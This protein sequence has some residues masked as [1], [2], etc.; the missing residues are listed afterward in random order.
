MIHKWLQV[1]VFISLIAGCASQPSSY[2][3]FTKMLLM[4]YLAGQ[5]KIYVDGK[6][7]FQLVF[8]V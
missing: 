1:L 6:L 7:K 4:K 3:N 8:L 5:Q 2:A